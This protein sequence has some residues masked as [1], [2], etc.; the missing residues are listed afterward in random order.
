MLIGQPV[1]AFSAPC[2]NLARSAPGA[3]TLTSRWE[4]VI[5]KPASS[6]SKVIV[7]FVSMRSDLMPAS[8][9]CADSAIV[10]Q[11]AWA[12]PSSSSGFVPGEPSKRVL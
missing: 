8:A 7:A 6:F 5:V 10:K 1:F 4:R 12:A 9:S 3:R 2:S 11:P